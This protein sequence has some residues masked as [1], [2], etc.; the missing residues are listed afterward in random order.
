MSNSVKNDTT[1]TC[2]MVE[3]AKRTARSRIV[4]PRE[5]LP[6]VLPFLPFLPFCRF[7]RSAVL[8]LLLLAADAAT[9][10]AAAAARECGCISAVGSLTQVRGRFSEHIG[11]GANFLIDK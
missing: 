11:S 7:C 1:A 5:S 2:E 4:E 10:S 6:A 3:P 8:L 9:A